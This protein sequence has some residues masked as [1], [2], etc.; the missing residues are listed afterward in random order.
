[1]KDQNEIEKMCEKAARECDR[2][3]APRHGMTYEEGVRAALD[4]VL[5]NMDDDETPFA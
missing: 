4:W 3:T 2:P 1:M 5:E